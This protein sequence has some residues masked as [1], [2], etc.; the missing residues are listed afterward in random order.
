[1]KETNLIM[2]INEALA[3]EMKR[4]EKVFIIGEDVQQGTFNITTGLVQQFGPDRVM[5][6]PIAETAIAG[7]AIGSAMLGYRPVAEFM[8]ADFMWVAANEVFLKAAKWRF[9]HGGKPTIPLTFL[10]AVGGGFNLGAEHSQTPTGV[11]MHSPGLKLVLPS[12]PYDAK[13]LL[14][15][16]IRDNNPVIFYFHKGM[17]GVHGNVGVEGEIPEEEYT[18]PL[19][20]ADIKRE[21][22]DVTVVAIG[23]MVR[24]ALE[25]AEQLKDKISL[26]VIDLRTLEPLDI[27]TVLESVKKT[28]RVVVVDEDV[29]RCGVTAEI[30]AQIT[31]NAFDHLDA[32]VKRVAAL[33]IPIPSGYVEPEVVPQIK[34]IIAAVEAL[35]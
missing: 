25:A 1:M 23:M 7:A 30:S 19:G 13:G 20:V 27:N 18:I 8:F 10:A 22:T 16:A 21:G 4:D 5:D 31:E 15:T 11:V 2:A 6:T 24:H 35:A 26:E 14:K 34:D 33:N 17:L 12:N 28:N 9:M 29:L 3:E 32:P